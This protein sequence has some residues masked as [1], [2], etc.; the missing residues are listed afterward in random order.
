MDP[1][2]MQLGYTDAKMGQCLSPSYATL[3][4]DPKSPIFSSSIR[5]SANT[6]RRIDLMQYRHTQEVNEFKSGQNNTTS[7]K[8]SMYSRRAG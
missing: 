4:P 1:R 5:A 6:D 3:G 2:N 7:G 8:V